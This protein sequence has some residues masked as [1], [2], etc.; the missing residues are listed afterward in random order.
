MLQ[1][2]PC[3]HVLGLGPLSRFLALLPGLEQLVTKQIDLLQHL[4]LVFAQS[5]VRE[6]LLED[7]LLLCIVSLVPDS[8]EIPRAMDR[9]RWRLR[10]R[11]DRAVDICTP[12][13]LPQ[14]QETAERPYHGIQLRRTPGATL[15]RSERIC[16]CDISAFMCRADSDVGPGPIL[17]VQSWASPAAE[18]QNSPY[19][20]WHRSMSR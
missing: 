15:A 14:G 9:I 16:L 11:L 7:L 5:G 12:L 8:N 4:R 13:A 17:P 20:W 2:T 1:H 10:D 6:T 19:F 18:S 3:I